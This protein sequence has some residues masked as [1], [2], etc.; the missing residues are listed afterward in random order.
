MGG[1][2]LLRR[3]EEPT[4]EAQRRN[5]E[6]AAAAV[7]ELAREHELVIT[8][9]NGP[10]VG[11]L[12]RQAARSGEG[13]PPLDVLSA[14]SVGMIGYLVAQELGS[15]LEDRPV[16]TLLT[17]VEV[18]PDDP[19]FRQPTKPI[20]PVLDEAEAR[21]FRD[22]YGWDM[23]PEGGGYRR[24]VPSPEPRRILEGETI[25]LLVSFGVVVVCG[26]GGGMPVCITG[27]G[28]IRGVE[29]V[30]D[31]D[32]TS[33]LLARELSADVLLLL[34]DVEAVYAGWGTP[35]ARP[36][37]R[38]TPDELRAMDLEAGSMGPKVRAACRFAEEADGWAVIGSLEDAPAM[39][40]G[41]AGTR[42]EV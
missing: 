12:A 28:W 32:A 15:R 22:A 34:T 38:A 23:A 29:A 5:L 36:M 1:N 31:K 7:A 33:A 37:A 40:R 6:S 2:A 18:D 3:G 4:T 42:V 16:A 13:Q 27:D 35:E 10:Q 20:G 9:G 19:A 21:H 11:L 24:V 26:G 8:H 39:L 17:L 41:E 14:E 25:R 30:V